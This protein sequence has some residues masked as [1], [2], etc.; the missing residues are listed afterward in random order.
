[1]LETSSRIYLVHVDLSHH[2]IVSVHPSSMLTVTIHCILWLQFTHMIQ[3]DFI[4][5][6]VIVI[7]EGKHYVL[8][9]NHHL[10]QILH[11]KQPV[12]KLTH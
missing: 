12:H 11:T 6:A 1:M 8:V 2:V 7:C 9:P 5:I 3:W 10:K 4:V